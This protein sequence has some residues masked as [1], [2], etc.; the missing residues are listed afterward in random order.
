MTIKDRKFLEIV[1]RE[2][3]WVKEPGESATY[4]PSSV[5]CKANKALEKKQREIANLKIKCLMM[6]GLHFG[7]RYL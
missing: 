7:P 5:K 6:M 2:M 4:E 1:K 3:E